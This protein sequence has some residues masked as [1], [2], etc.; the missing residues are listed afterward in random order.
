MAAASIAVMQKIAV[1]GS[2]SWEAVLIP[3]ALMRGWVRWKSKMRW[4]SVNTAKKGKTEPI[5][6][7]SANEA[8]TMRPRRSPNWPFLRE[9]K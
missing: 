9:L 5:L 2:S 1:S 3:R 8:N 6:R 4:G 7:I